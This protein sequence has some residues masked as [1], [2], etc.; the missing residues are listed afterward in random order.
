MWMIAC[1]FR[2]QAANW[3]NTKLKIKLWYQSFLENKKFLENKETACFINSIHNLAN[4]FLFLTHVE[5]HSLNNLTIL[6]GRSL[7]PT[8]MVAN[9]W[10]V[11]TNLLMDFTDHKNILAYSPSNM[12][13]EHSLIFLS[14]WCSIQ[15]DPQWKTQIWVQKSLCFSF[16]VYGV[17]SSLKVNLP[18]H[19]KTKTLL[20]LG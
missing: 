13:P 11:E 17:S 6:W 2:V 20:T 5:A 19:E 1:N 14:R 18:K 15:N 12:M 16:C 4:I 3:E 8:P 9:P 7:V 10:I